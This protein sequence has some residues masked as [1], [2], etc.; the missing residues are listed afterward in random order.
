MKKLL[1]ITS[2]AASL[3]VGLHAE[4]AAAPAAPATTAP[5]APAAGE[6]MTVI[7]IG[8]NKISVKPGNGKDKSI[9]STK[10]TVTP[11]TLITINGEAAQLTQIKPGHKVIITPIAGQSDVAAT[12]S[13]SKK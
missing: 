3:T 5:G 7:F 11:D 12:I 6:K 10:Y 2:I 4:E 1:L 8:P 9:E 13:M